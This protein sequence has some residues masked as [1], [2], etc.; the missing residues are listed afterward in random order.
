MSDDCEQDEAA[1]PPMAGSRV[2]TREDAP[3]VD[4][5][6][7]GEYPE[8]FMDDNADDLMDDEGDGF[9]DCGM[10]PDA[11][12]FT[13]TLF[14]SEECEFCPNRR[15]LHRENAERIRGDADA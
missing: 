11:K 15:H 4:S 13:C 2:P 7:D 14:G 9:D 1:L 8:Y 6:W 12:S 10:M 5:S 3:I